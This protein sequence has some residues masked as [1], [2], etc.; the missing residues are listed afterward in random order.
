MCCI[1]VTIRR[2]GPPV[3]HGGPFVDISFILSEFYTTLTSVYFTDGRWQ[4]EGRK[5]SSVHLRAMV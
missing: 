1:H 5:V 3:D 4:L 2:R